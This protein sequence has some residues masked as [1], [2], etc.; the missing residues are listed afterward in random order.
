MCAS[1][2]IATVYSHCCRPVHNRRL[3]IF[4][5]GP[6]MNTTTIADNCQQ[7]SDMMIAIL[8]N[9]AVT[10]AGPILYGLRKY[11]RARCKQQCNISI[12]S[13]IDKKPA[14]PPRSV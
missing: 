5:D 6:E 12:D 1:E 7:N 11:M 3:Y 2:S 13:E 8:A 10:V 14:D 4:F 9:S